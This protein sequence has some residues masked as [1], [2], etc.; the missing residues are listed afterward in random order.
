MVV[1]VVA[2]RGIVDVADQGR[3]AKAFSGWKG[4]IHMH[5]PRAWCVY[6]CVGV[7][8]CPKNTTG[9]KRYLGFGQC[10]RVQSSEGRGSGVKEG[11]WE[12]R[13]REG[14]RKKRGSFHGI[15]S[16]VF[17]SGRA[18]SGWVSCIWHHW[19]GVVTRYLTMG[20]RPRSHHTTDC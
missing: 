13:K 10:R 19:R 20:I 3:P 18:G 17:R 5:S 6:A 8:L 15:D 12:R 14:K 9:E 11:K 1:V 7:C 4:I 16:G 2:R